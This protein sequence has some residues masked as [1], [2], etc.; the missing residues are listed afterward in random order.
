MNARTH[1]PRGF[2]LIELL[3]SIAIIAVLISLILPSLS[4]ARK[5]GQA[6]LCLSNLHTLGQGLVMYTMEYGDVL[7]PGRLPKVDDTNWYADIAGGRKYRPTFLAMM[8]SN[9]GVAPFDDP[10]ANKTIMDRFGE[11]GDRQNYGNKVFVCPGVT[12]WTDERNGSYGYNYQFLGN[13]RLSD[14]SDIHSFKN[15]PVIAT[16][17]RDTSNTVAVGDCMGTAASYVPRERMPYEN[18]SRDP[19]RFGNEGFNLDPPLV[20]PANGEMAGLDEGHRTATDPRHLQRTNILWVDGHANSETMESLGY[21]I[22]L[23]GII[24]FNGRNDRWSGTGRNVAWTP[25][26]GF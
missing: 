10:Q 2:T 3:V 16:R 14:E 8:G 23:D 5:S 6:T 26:Y 4:G 7:L 9:I 25:G 11:P 18:N 15:W 22:A 13:S 21:E 20:D 24:G 19:E 1:R 17:V 12:D